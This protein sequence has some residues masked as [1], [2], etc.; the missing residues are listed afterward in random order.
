[1]GCLVVEGGNC[2]REAQDCNKHSK[3]TPQIEHAQGRADEHAGAAEGRAA[4][5]LLPCCPAEGHGAHALLP[6]K[7]TL[8]QALTKRL[9]LC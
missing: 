1:V 5:A 8:L 6:C 2:A 3:C 9:L 4:H 7:P